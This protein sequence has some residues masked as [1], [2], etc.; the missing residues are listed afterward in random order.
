MSEKYKARLAEM[1]AD[2]TNE[3]ASVGIHNPENPSDWIAVPEDL[4]A[5]EPDLN[6]AADSVEEW[7]ERSALVA[8]LEKRYND[9]TG[10]LNRI[11]KG[12]FGMCE[13]CKNPIEEK[14]LDAI[15]TARTCIAH[16]AEEE[17]LP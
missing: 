8:T 17:T 4:D 11:K 3:L 7:N 15:P 9:V 16:L 13:M 10:A 14:R 2:V 5:E 1:L 6:L 12:T